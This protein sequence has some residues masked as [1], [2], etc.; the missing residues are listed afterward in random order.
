MEQHAE[1]SEQTHQLVRSLLKLPEAVFEHLV[2][3][4]FPDVHLHMN[5]SE[6]EN[7]ELTAPSGGKKQP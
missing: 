3:S 4:L 7:L 6:V 1:Q 5:I 2:V